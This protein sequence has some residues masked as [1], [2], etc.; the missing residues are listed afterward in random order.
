MAGC[1]GA[2]AAAV[3]GAAA[4]DVDVAVDG[5]GAE[6]ARDGDDRRMTETGD[7]SGELRG[8]STINFARDSRHTLG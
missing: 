6:G 1:G 7:A 8:G 3:A 2:A 4:A 5:A